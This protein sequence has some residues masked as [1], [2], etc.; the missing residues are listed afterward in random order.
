MYLRHI[1]TNSLT[2]ASYIMGEDQIR[3]QKKPIGYLNDFDEVHVHD[4]L[5]ILHTALD[6]AGVMFRGTENKEYGVG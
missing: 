2:T 4:L 3:K 1:P 6:F 5:H